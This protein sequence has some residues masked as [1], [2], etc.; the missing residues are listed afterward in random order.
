[1]LDVLMYA[2]A[3]TT[4]PRLV[5]RSFSRVH[6]GTLNDFLRDHHP[7]NVHSSIQEKNKVAI[8]MIAE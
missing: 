7:Y 6:L 8:V 4:P 3:Y 5:Y 1:M 2:C